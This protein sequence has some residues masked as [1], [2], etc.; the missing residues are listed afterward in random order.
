M[1]PS[2]TATTKSK[3]DKDQI[4]QQ[5]AGAATTGRGS[6]S[7]P[8]Q[9]VSTNTATS[10]TRTNNT[11]SSSISQSNVK[12]RSSVPASRPGA[13]SSLS[14]P[15]AVAGY[16]SSSSSSM[17]PSSTA[18]ASEPLAPAMRTPA[19]D[20]KASYRSTA[21]SSTVSKP[22]AV[23]VEP[24]SSRSILTTDS[25][26]KLDEKASYR[27]APVG[28]PSSVSDMEEETPN[29][30]LP[31]T[32]HE[33][34][35]EGED[36]K[37]SSV[38][39]QT[40]L[41]SEPLGPVTTNN[42]TS[43]TMDSK[44]RFRATPA[45]RPGAMAVP[46]IAAAANESSGGDASMVDAQAAVAA[47]EADAW[48]KKSA[49]AV[50]P[51]TRPGAV[52]V[53][54][55][56]V[57]ST[58]GSQAVSRAD[59]VAMVQA[60]ESDLLIKQQS[61]RSE[62]A[63]Q[64]GASSVSFSDA[65]G[66]T[67]LAV[68]Q[69]EESDL[70]IKQQSK[71]SEKAQQPGASMSMS[72]ADAGAVMEAVDSDDKIKQ[73]ASSSQS[74]MSG[75]DALAAAQTVETDKE[76]YSRENANT[77]TAHPGAVSSSATSTNKDEDA[78]RSKDDETMMVAGLA[79]AATLG[80]V[81]ATTAALSSNDEQ[82]MTPGGR[83]LAFPSDPVSTEPGAVR[84]GMNATDALKDE[85]SEYLEAAP[86]V[87]AVNISK[88]DV[89][90]GM[91]EPDG[92]GLVVAAPVDEEAEKANLVSAEDF[93]RRKQLPVYRRPW[94]LLAL[95]SIVCICLAGIITGVVV[96]ADNDSDDDEDGDD[97]QVNPEQTPTSSPTMAPTTME[98]AEWR[99]WLET[100]ILAET[101]NTAP[102]AFEM[103]LNWF[104]NEDT[105]PDRELYN[106][107]SD[108][109]WL[110]ER[111]IMAWFYFIS[112]ANGTKPW[113]SCNPPDY[114]AGHTNECVFLDGEGGVSIDLSYINF[115]QVP[116]QPRWLSNYS[117]CEW[118]GIVCVSF[119]ARWAED[120]RRAEL[121]AACN[122]KVSE[123]RL[124]AFGLRGQL[125]V[126]TNQLQ[127]FNALTITFNSELTGTIPL[128][129][130]NFSKSLRGFSSL[131]LS[132]NTLSGSIPEEIFDL[133]DIRTIKL[134][135]NKFTGA[136]PS[137][138]G[139][140]P[141]ITQL[142]LNGNSFNAPLP[143]LDGTNHPRLNSL[144]LNSAGF[145]GPIPSDYGTL[146]RLVRFWLNDNRLTGP[147]PQSFVNLTSR[148]RDFRV[149]MNQLGGE[150]PDIFWEGL[151]LFYVHTNQFEGQLPPQLYRMTNLI[152]F[153]VEENNFS[154]EIDPRVSYIL[155]LTC[156][157]NEFGGVFEE[158]VSTFILPS[159]LV[160]RYVPMQ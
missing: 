68:V 73:R 31:T 143:I 97:D 132:N 56:V 50:A 131:V 147:I 160:H 47:V 19:V 8:P 133:P 55:G 2:D 84:G 76:K 5:T 60:E 85:P 21:S 134:Q 53:E 20:E 90:F 87:A 43:A 6:A 28:R 142:W 22:G 123:L 140:I 62:K 29:D 40:P 41:A 118:P 81:V 83:D 126:V 78:K 7:E 129:L 12:V 75:M 82:V 121:Y 27:M 100:Q 26:S 158:L 139:R 130:F 125:P 98:V 23:A 59:S 117:Q 159:S 11:S 16:S 9:T 94:F 122:G 99:S 37:D 69:A 42:N 86:S 63:Q 146:Q 124:I 157:R 66:A 15:G 110:Y 115:T 45:A 77:G 80:G 136:L 106:T 32:I 111:F 91:D 34:E 1:E 46:G 67:A 30:R 36:E 33:E 35:D 89:E 14:Y 141:S 38:S 149:E 95:T 120:P 112:T 101:I 105:N 61:K 135:N 52:A 103:A 49:A 154:G 108:S 58:S 88:L 128:E 113:L 4:I 137:F 51:A 48:S 64:P 79:A 70:L 39:P 72:I 57:A 96:G 156:Q 44:T 155:I 3:Q 74:T 93:T 25:S 151:E 92:E 127:C 71:R 116:D 148:L 102:V 18:T 150:F 144:Q 13:V 10:L 109:V 107:T 114:E 54:P 145:F 119:P 153:N 24:S 138:E 65:G 152:Q 104:A 17:R